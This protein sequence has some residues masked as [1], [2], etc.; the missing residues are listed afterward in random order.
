MTL[1][2][3]LKSGNAKLWEFLES[4]FGVRPPKSLEAGLTSVEPAMTRSFILEECAR[5][6]QR[7]DQSFAPRPEDVPLRDAVHL[8]EYKVSSLVPPQS[9][10]PFA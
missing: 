1:G 6:L 4:H 5:V 8:P 10:E 2:D 3:C 9:I 7:P